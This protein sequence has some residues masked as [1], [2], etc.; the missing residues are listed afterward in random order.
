MKRIASFIFI[1]SFCLP[2]FSQNENKQEIAQYIVT[3]NVKLENKCK[4]P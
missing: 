2:L 1:Y 4:L 3:Y